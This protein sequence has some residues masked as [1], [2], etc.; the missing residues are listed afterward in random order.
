MTRRASFFVPSLLVSCAALCAAV[1]ACSSDDKHPSLIAAGGSAPSNGG[2]AGSTAGGPEPGEGGSVPDTNTDGG[3]GG[4]YPSGG[5]GGLVD[6]DG[7]Q[8]GTGEPPVE[9]SAC[10]DK[11]VWSGA[12]NVDAVSSAASETL[13][14]VTADELDLA[15]LR[16]GALYVAHRAQ[17]SATFSIGA[18][19][20]IPTGWSAAQGAALSADGRRLLLVSDPDQKKLGEMTRSSRGAAF[21]GSVD[22]SAFAAVNEDAV[23]TGRLYASPAVS[24]TDQQLFF[25][26]SFPGGAST[27]VVSTATVDA[28]WSTP[29]QLT[30]LLL[31]G[32]SA[33]ERRLPSAI[34]VDQRTLFYFNEQTMTEEARFREAPNRTSPPYDLVSLGM[35][36]GATPNTAC[37]RLY[38]ASGGDVVVEK[39]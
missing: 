4:A 38:S 8:I 1:G 12:S 34:S 19:V 31:D 18:P 5:S 16:G 27:V 36:R 11:A 26:S 17:S 25:N 13:L 21:A 32:D 6:A 35:R 3:E 29:L 7:G 2:H 15:F 24:P 20:A 10:S 39:D 23:Y 22:E 33:A 30:P 9:P 14:S 28:G 37:D